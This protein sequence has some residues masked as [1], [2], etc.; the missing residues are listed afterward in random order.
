MSSSWRPGLPASTNLRKIVP[1]W[2]AQH[3]TLSVQF[4]KVYLE[5]WLLKDSG[6]T[7][8]C[9]SALTITSVS[10]RTTHISCVCKERAWSLTKWM[11]C[12]LW[13]VSV[14]YN[15]AYDSCIHGIP[16]ACPWISTWKSEL[17]HDRNMLAMECNAWLFSLQH[18]GTWLSH[19]HSILTA[20]LAETLQRRLSFFHFFRVASL[21]SQISISIEHSTP[22]I[23]H[24]VYFQ[25]VQP[26]TRNFKCKCYQ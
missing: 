11:W 13:Y 20:M 21:L 4:H 8:S 14:S 22:Q 15:L 24:S 23:Y 1:P 2:H 16:I 12:G 19:S 18:W 26:A 7:L 9:K 6:K 10:H 5:V 3:L 25:R 17:S